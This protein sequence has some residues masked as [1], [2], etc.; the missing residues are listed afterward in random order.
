MAEKHTVYLEFE[1]PDGYRPIRHRDGSPVLDRLAPGQCGLDMTS[2]C[3][4]QWPETH[5]SGSVYLL[6]KRIPTLPP[7]PEG[8]FSDKVAGLAMDE[9]DEGDESGIWYA[10]FMPPTFDAETRR[11][12]T[13]ALI[14]F[15]PPDRLFHR[16]FFPTVE[17]KDSWWPNPNWKG[18]IDG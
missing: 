17:P 15:Q 10:Y 5:C 8:V 3:V 14:C 16:D 2:G 1:I 12:G 6:L 7:F 9:G 18:P 11:W 4:I 13:D